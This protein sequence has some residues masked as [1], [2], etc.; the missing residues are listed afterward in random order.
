MTRAAGP[1]PSPAAHAAAA[2][3]A[4][5][6]RATAPD[7]PL[8]LPPFPGRA[9]RARRTLR[10]Y[11]ELLRAPAAITVPGDVL[12]GALAA[13]RGPAPPPPGQGRSARGRCW[14]GAGPPA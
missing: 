5:R 11:A 7:G 13:G 8:R 10:A 2:G 3:R 14:A 12:A 6:P 9:F 1:A 4:R